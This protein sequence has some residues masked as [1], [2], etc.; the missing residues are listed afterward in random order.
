MFMADGRLPLGLSSTF[1][2]GI[3]DCHALRISLVLSV[4]IPSTT[5]TSTEAA[6]GSNEKTDLRQPSMYFISFLHGMMIEIPDL[7][8]LPLFRPACI[9]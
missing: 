6:T 4:D 3:L 1:S 5:I 9:S 7:S 8:D 2:S